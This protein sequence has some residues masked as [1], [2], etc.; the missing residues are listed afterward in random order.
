MLDTS[1]VS[2][3][4]GVHLIVAMP[5]DSWLLCGG[6]E[7][8]GSARSDP[9]TPP[10]MFSDPCEVLLLTRYRSH[11]SEYIPD[12]DLENLLKN[13]AGNGAF[14]DVCY[15]RVDPPNWSRITFLLHRLLEAHF[16]PTH[17]MVVIIASGIYTFIAKGQ[18][19]TLKIMWTFDICGYIRL[20]GFS[21]VA[22]YFILYENFHRICV[23]K[24]KAEMKAAGL[25]ENMAHSFSYRTFWGNILDYLMVPIAAPLFG[26]IPAIHAQMSHF[27][28]LDLVY[29]VSKKPSN[30]RGP[31]L[32]S[33]V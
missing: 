10:G 20:F 24:R 4:C 29:T 3:I 23:R 12:D 6:T 18:P 7:D 31:Q 14:S 9:C 21:L 16:F 8:A 25:Y 17:M 33:Q 11:K 27:W 13:Q 1:R 19:D 2:G 30:K 26:S 28:T 15:H 5:C 22:L 32:E